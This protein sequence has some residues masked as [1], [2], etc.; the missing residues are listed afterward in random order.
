MSNNPTCERHQG[1]FACKQI[2]TYIQIAISNY[3]LTGY[4]CRLHVS[5][6][7][8]VSLRMKT[9]LLLGNHHHG[10]DYTDWF[11]K[12]KSKLLGLCALTLKTTRL[13]YMYC[14]LHFLK[15][16]ML[17]T[18]H[19]V[20]VKD[21]SSH[22]V[23]QHMHKITNL[24]KFEL[25]W[26]SKFRDNNERKEHPHHTKLCALG[27]LISRLQILNLRSQNQICG[28]LLLSRKLC[29]FRE[30]RF[31]QCYIPSNSPN[32]SLPSKVLC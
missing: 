11:M 20:I 2:R 24:R 13:D 7:L 4:Q 31:S 8:T 9:S 1:G 19:L 18:G 23:F 27:R 26:S 5:V 14:R 15:T 17:H 3:V 21:Q 32:F 6:A 30:N 25:N 12:L 16:I 28:K 29:H 10:E 22:L